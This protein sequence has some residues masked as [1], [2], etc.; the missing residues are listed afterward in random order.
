MGG[1]NWG[2]VVREERLRRSRQDEPTPF[3]ETPP[4]RVSRQHSQD[5]PHD[6]RF[7]RHFPALL[8]QRARLHSTYTATWTQLGNK[9]LE[10]L[11]SAAAEGDVL[12]FATTKQGQECVMAGG[13]A[14]S[15]AVADIPTGWKSLEAADFRFTLALGLAEE[16]PFRGDWWIKVCEPDV[17]ETE[18][19]ATLQLLRELWSLS[20]PR[21]LRWCQVNLELLPARRSGPSRR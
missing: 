12:I 13:E 15:F 19:S 3:L 9:T 21:E 18:V 17:A 4:L 1:F 8:D 10:L 5:E 6:D 7:P 20:T 16:S 2:R 11:A 14:P